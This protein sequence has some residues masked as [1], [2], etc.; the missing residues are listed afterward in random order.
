MEDGRWMKIYRKRLKIRMSVWKRIKVRK[1]EEDEGRK[2]FF[3]KW[4]P[5][6]KT[7]GIPSRAKNWRGLR[8]MTCEGRESG[9]EERG[10]KKKEASPYLLSRFACCMISGD[11]EKPRRLVRSISCRI[12]F[13]KKHAALE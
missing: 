12:R 2:V 9:K 4:E 1:N 10:G 8:F 7:P 6:K 13:Q 5:T 3:D 11:V